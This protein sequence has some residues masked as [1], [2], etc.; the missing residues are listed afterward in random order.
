MKI[1]QK[2]DIFTRKSHKKRIK[3]CQKSVKKWPKNAYSRAKSGGCCAIFRTN[4]LARATQIAFI[5]SE[6]LGFSRPRVHVRG[7][8]YARVREAWARAR[9]SWRLSQLR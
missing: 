1:T 8:V 9:E 3:K 6:K 5:C 2:C 4:F 7:R